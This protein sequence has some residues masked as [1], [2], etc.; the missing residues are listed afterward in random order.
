VGPIHDV[1]PVGDGQ[2][3]WIA[4]PEANRVLRVR[5]PLDSPMV[6]VILGQADVDGRACNRGQVP[7]PNQGAKA[8]PADMLCAPG[9]VTVD[10]AGNVYVSDHTIEAAG[11]WRL[12]VFAA[13][14]FPD[15]SDLPV[16]GPRATKVFPYRAKHPAATFKPVIDRAGRMIVGYNPYLSGRF[17]G[18]YAD[19]LGPSVDADVFFRDLNSLPWALA[20][21]EDGNLYVADSNRHRVLVYLRP[22]ADGIPAA[23]PEPE[24]ALLPLVLAGRR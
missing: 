7:P 12:L 3:V 17:L 24:R 20:L 14:L 11:N 2:A 10:P 22:L 4:E 13:A 21:D 1:A 23:P 15:R 9:A 8:A 5:H 6:D 19:P 18:A 16:L